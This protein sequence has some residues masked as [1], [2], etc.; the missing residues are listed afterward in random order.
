MWW[1]ILSLFKRHKKLIARILNSQGLELG[2]DKRE[3][4]IL[5]KALIYILDQKKELKAIDY[6]LN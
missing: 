3:T 6:F 2:H 4:I 1:F 5:Q